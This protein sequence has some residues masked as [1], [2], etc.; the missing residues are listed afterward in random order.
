MEKVRSSRVR[1]NFVAPHFVVMLFNVLAFYLKSNGKR[2]SGREL[3][4]IFCD[5]QLENQLSD[6]IRH[7]AYADEKWI[8]E[9]YKTDFGILKDKKKNPLRPP[10]PNTFQKHCLTAIRNVDNAEIKKFFLNLSNVATTLCN[11]A[12][13]NF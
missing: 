10:Q 3:G 2:Y 4:R 8:R 7:D 5:A 9:M 12:P 1:N 13:E 11:E 6:D